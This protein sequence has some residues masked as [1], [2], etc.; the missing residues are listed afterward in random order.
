MQVFL[1]S[2]G[3]GQLFSIRPEQESAA[4]AHGHWISA[5]AIATLALARTWPSGACS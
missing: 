4:G 5:N 3:Q 2:D 1:T